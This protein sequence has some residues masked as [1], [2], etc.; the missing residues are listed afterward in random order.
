ME[1]W[2]PCLNVIII[3]FYIFL[4][5]FTFV[6]IVL[7]SPVTEN[8]Q[9]PSIHISNNQMGH[10][11]V[12]LSDNDDSDETTAA[13]TSA[14]P[15]SIK[16]ANQSFYDDLPGLADFCQFISGAPRPPRQMIRV[17]FSTDDS[18]KLP[19]AETCFVWL[20]LPVANTS[21]LEFRQNMDIALKFEATGFYIM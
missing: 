11:L 9:V 14:E 10:E 1:K 2:T 7:L 18:Q 17:R 16:G 6:Y 15:Y 4:L 5:K 3:I 20:V 19:V 12:V 13:A 8:R 21:Y